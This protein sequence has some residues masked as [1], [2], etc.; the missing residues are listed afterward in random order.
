[1]AKK[2]DNKMEQNNGL[3]FI[4][5]VAKY[6]MDFLETDFH[7]RRNPKRS[8]QLRNSSN[9][10][11]GLNLNR[12][13]SFNALVW[14]AVTHGFDHNV[15]NTIQAGV[16]QTNIPKNLLGLIGLQLG[17]IK[18]KQI[19]EIIDKLAE[20]IEKSI[21]PHLKEYDQALTSSLEVTE[22]EIK[23]ELVLPLDR[24]SVV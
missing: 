18:S 6:F 12:Y 22:K 1:M 8:V 23:A 15:L 14:K 13:P 17:K 20:E 9:L 21:A 5:E 3:A 4:K 11:I 16:Y 10:L 24:K 19:S 7:K 2:A